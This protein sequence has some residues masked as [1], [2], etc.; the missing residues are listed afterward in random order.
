MRAREIAGWVALAGA[1]WLALGYALAKAQARP[2][3]SPARFQRQAGKRVVACLGA[4]MIHGRVS[5]DLVSA[6]EERLG[7]SFQVVNAGVNGD[8]AWNA[9]QRLPSVVE[10]DPDYVIVMVGSNDVMASLNPTAEA[11]Y[12]RA[13]KL[14]V[15]PSLDW[16][17]EN[18]RGIVIELRSRT[19]AKLAVC[20]LP[21]LGEVLDAR[22]NRSLAQYNEVVREVAHENGCDYLPVHE[23]LRDALA[24]A[25]PPE[26]KPYDGS[27]WPLVRAIFDRYVLGL[28]LEAI[29]ARQGYALLT[30]GIHLGARAGELVVDRFEAFVR[31]ASLRAVPETLLR[32]H[33]TDRAR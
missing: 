12:R 17:R 14:P 31:R 24:S 22:A 1:P 6:L 21:P 13:K 7:T 16:Y 29:S 18:L 28:P 11:R 30:D 4:S 10:C 19:R 8:L 27:P 26:A 23:T 2:L 32:A 9:R 33:G 3:Q 5:F 25:A 20:S 15:R